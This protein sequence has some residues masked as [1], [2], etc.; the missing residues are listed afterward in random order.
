MSLRTLGLS[1]AGPVFKGSSL[2]YDTVTAIER[3]VAD[4]KWAGAEAAIAAARRSG[5]N[6][7]WY[8]LLRQPRS[9]RQRYHH[10]YW[11]QFYLD[12]DLV[13]LAQR[14]GDARLERAV[15]CAFHGGG[16]ASLTPRGGRH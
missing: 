15:D 9:I 6:L 4:G 13:D 14:R 11:L 2:T 8:A 10:G 16:W 7:D 5:L 3:R 12:R 1:N